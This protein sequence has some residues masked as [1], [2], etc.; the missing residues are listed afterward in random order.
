ML[1]SIMCQAHHLYFL[2]AAGV[3]FPYCKLQ[4]DN[5]LKVFRKHPTTN[6]FAFLPPLQRMS[7]KLLL[8][9]SN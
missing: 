5:G 2:S 9:K 8:R 4:G 6:Y 3:I 7:S 1:R